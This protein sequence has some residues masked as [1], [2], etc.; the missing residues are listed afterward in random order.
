ML[1]P[2]RVTAVP[3]YVKIQLRLRFFLE[4][5]LTDPCALVEYSKKAGSTREDS[6]YQHAKDLLNLPFFVP[7]NKPRRDR[8]DVGTTA[9][10]EQHN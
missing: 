10:H 6:V 2:H 3:L 4:P 7:V 9:N 8:S 1:M 5:T